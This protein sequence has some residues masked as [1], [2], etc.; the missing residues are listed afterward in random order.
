[1]REHILTFIK[2]SWFKDSSDMKDQIKYFVQNPRRRRQMFQLQWSK[3]TSVIICILI[4][5]VFCFSDT[6]NALGY[7]FNFYFC[8]QHKR[9]LFRWIYMFSFKNIF[10]PLQ[11]GRPKQS[12]YDHRAQQIAGYILKEVFTIVMLRGQKYIENES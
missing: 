5:T 4:H 2:F 12:R 3:T 7:R 10:K 8:F 11:E 6:Y 1:M 9:A